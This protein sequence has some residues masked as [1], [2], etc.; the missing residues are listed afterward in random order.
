MTRHVL[1]GRRPMLLGLGAA[2]LPGMAEAAAGPKLRSKLPVLARHEGVWEGV[3]RRYNP[4]GDKMT[5]FKSQ[6]ITRFFPDAQWPD[7]YHQTNRYTKDDGSVQVLE[8]KGVFKDDRLHFE[9]DRVKGWTIDDPTD[10]HKRQCLLF[11]EYT[12]DPGAYVYEMIQ[13]SD[14]GR[15]R[16]RMTQFVKE[17][18]TQMRTTID[19]Q[20]VSDDWAKYDAGNGKAP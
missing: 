8:T 3:F 16:T 18:R 1:F 11:M 6:L 9:S 12:N 2:A 14:D 20:K 17:G 7:I 5:E 13:L 4:A 10:P 19:E 15:S